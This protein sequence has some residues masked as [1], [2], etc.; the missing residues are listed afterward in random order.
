[1]HNLNFISMT[2]LFPVLVVPVSFGAFYN[3]ARLNYTNIWDFL[4][5]AILF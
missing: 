1:M 3:E 2:T 4:N 5:M